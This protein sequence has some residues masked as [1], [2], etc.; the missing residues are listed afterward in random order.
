MPSMSS[1]SAP[2]IAAAVARPPETC[3]ILSASP[4]TTRA[5]TWTACSFGARSGWV[6]IATIWRRTPAPLTPR[7]QVSAALWT[8]KVEPLRQQLGATSSRMLQT[9]DRAQSLP[10]APPGEYEIL[11]FATDF[12]HKPGAV[13]T[14]VLAHESSGWRVDGYFIK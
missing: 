10:G 12:A 11:Q 1:S 6:R 9:V 13:E 3:T 8:S 7:S 2:G 5:G 4:W 14:V